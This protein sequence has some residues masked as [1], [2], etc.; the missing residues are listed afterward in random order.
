MKASNP[1]AYSVLNTNTQCHPLPMTCIID[2]S[3]AHEH[4]LATVSHLNLTCESIFANLCYRNAR[5]SYVLER[6]NMPY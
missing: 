4:I 1:V 6:S 2:P 3:K 5:T